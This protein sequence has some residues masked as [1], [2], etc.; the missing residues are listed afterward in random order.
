MSK[1]LF[2]VV[3]T[4]DAIERKVKKLNRNAI[5]QKYPQKLEAFRKTV[6]SNVVRMWSDT[7]GIKLAILEKL[8]ELGL[9]DDIVGWIREER[10]PPYSGEW[11]GHVYWTDDWARRLINPGNKIPNFTP[12]HPR[13]EGNLYIYR[14]TSGVYKGFSTWTVMNNETQVSVAA[15]LASN[16]VISDGELKSCD[17][18]AHSR[19]NVLEEASYGPSPLYTWSFS[20]IGTTRL[21]GTMSTIYKGKA[22]DVGSVLLERN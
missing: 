6:L 3:I 20:E 18:R 10:L 2:A 21:R 1:A 19:R 17:V 9:R 7:T 8:P 13:S 4:E 22:I 16:F 5:E 12:I 11:E 15:V 14:S